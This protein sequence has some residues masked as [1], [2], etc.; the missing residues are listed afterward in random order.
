MERVRIGGDGPWIE[1][2]SFIALE[3]HQPIGAIF[4]TLLPDGD[5]CE[6]GSY[7]WL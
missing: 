3:N 5:P 1:R 7:E 6:F 2:A 4:I